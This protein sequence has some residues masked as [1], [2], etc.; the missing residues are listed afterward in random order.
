MS[1]IVGDE[2]CPRCR[3]EGK[4]KTGN[5]LIRFEDGGAFCNRCDY[6][7]T[8]KSKEST[9]VKL[10]IN[11]IETLPSFKARGIRGS[12]RDKFGVKTA[13]STE[14]GKTV[15]DIYYPRYRQGHLTGYKS[16]IMPKTFS[17]VGDCKD[18]DLWGRW[19][20]LEGDRRPIN[21]YRKMEATCHG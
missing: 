19:L 2:A 20:N 16:R 1:R 7:E 10:G 12:I 21:N 17:C 14:D 3:A 15:T 9:E 8:G 5:H 6:K 18:S 4:D 11:E 13:V